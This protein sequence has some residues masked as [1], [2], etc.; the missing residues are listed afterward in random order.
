MR[1]LVDLDGTEIEI[2]ESGGAYPYLSK[3]GTLL[4]EARAGH[5]DGIGI[6]E[7][8]NLTVDLA[9]DG[10]K[11]STLL[12]RPLRATATVYDDDDDEFFAG[13]VQAVSYGTTMGLTL[14]A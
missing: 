6:G 11:A 13:I 10:N 5:L 3:V 1:L 2:T 7:S 9:N 8:A 12:G 14:E 4:L